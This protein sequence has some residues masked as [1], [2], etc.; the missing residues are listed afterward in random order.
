MIDVVDYESL[1]SKDPDTVNK[2]SEL[3][4]QIEAK[5]AEVV[6][7]REHLE[8]D[9]EVDMTQFSEELKRLQKA[10]DIVQKMCAEKIAPI[11]NEYNERSSKLEAKQKYMESMEEIA[12]ERLD[13]LQLMNNKIDD[14]T[15][16]LEDPVVK[17]VEEVVILPL[18]KEAAKLETDLANMMRNG[19]L[20]AYSEK[21]LGKLNDEI[22]RNVKDSEYDEKKQERRID[23]AKQDISVRYSKP[24]P[25]KI[26]QEWIN[27]NKVLNKNTL[28]LTEINNAIKLY[29]D[30]AKKLSSQNR[31][32]NDKLSSLRDEFASLQRF[33]PGD[34]GIFHDKG[35]LARA[36]MTKKEIEN[37]KLNMK[38][39]IAKGKYK[40]DKNRLESLQEKLKT[41]PSAIKANQESLQ[42]AKNKRNEIENDLEKSNAIE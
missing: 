18:T 33:L 28:F 7:L 11:Q 14:T 25:P 40:V 38:L 15:A 3:R 37:D 19:Q 22:Q 17:P 34:D 30:E 26:T 5:E 16:K 6:R 24:K 36:E 27:A 8:R 35:S 12:K 20:D 29:N 4:D 10:F 39:L 41:F 2:V 23:T 42:K 13:F 32:D 21:Q 31:A 9:N 1:Y